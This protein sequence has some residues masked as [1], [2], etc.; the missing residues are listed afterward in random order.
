MGEGI[1]IVGMACRYPDA[2][3]AGRAVGERARRRR[4]FRRVPPERL[5][6]EDYCRATGRT[7]R[8]AST[9]RGRGDRGLRVRPRALPRRRPHLPL[10]RPRPLAGARRRGPGPGR[11]RLPRGRGPAARRDRRAA[12]QHADRRVLPRPIDAAAL[13]VRAPHP[14]RGPGRRRVGRRSGSRTSSPAWSRPTRRR[15]RSP[16]RRRWPAA[17]PTPSPGGSATTST[18]RAAATPSTA[19][20]PPRCSRWPPP[21]QGWPRATSTS[22]SPAASTCSLDPFELVGFARTGALRRDEMRVYDARSAG[23]WPGEGC[24][25]VVLMRDADA[26]R[27]AAA[28]AP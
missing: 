15:S 4:A 21:A 26:A 24:G 18:S 5:R 28:C 11:R 3:I 1:A 12:G 2:R 23:F 8:T 14:R 27:P 10:R 16:W 6:L 17:S 13:A 7:I 9:L 20:A 22:P 25:F 19:P